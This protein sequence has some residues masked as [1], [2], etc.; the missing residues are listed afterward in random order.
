MSLHHRQQHWPWSILLVVQC[1][2]RGHQLEG[3]GRRHCHRLDPVVGDLW[4]ASRCKNFAGLVEVFRHSPLDFWRTMLVKSCGFPPGFGAKAGEL[5]P[6]MD[7]VENPRCHVDEESGVVVW[8]V[9]QFPRRYGCRACGSAGVNIEGLHVRVKCL[10]SMSSGLVVSSL[11][12]QLPCFALCN[13]STIAL[14]R[15]VLHPVTPFMPFRTL[16]ITT[17]SHHS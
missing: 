8:S 9:S 16:R 13:S 11:G 14:A 5:E 17:S 6:H 1:L 2:M 15:F 7:N 10:V 4:P 3:F 12:T